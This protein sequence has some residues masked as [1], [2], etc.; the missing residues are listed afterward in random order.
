M[1]EKR[2]LQTE[3]RS[4]RDAKDKCAAVE[5]RLKGAST[6]FSALTQCTRSPSGHSE[7]EAALTASRA[8]EKLLTEHQSTT[9]ESNVRHFIRQLEKWKEAAMAGEPRFVFLIKRILVY[10]LFL[11]CRK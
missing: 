10:A 8:K 1:K 11:R 9:V 2:A 6:L 4:L 5:K 7:T 3:L